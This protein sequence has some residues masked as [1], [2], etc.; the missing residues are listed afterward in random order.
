MH[1]RLMELTNLIIYCECYHLHVNIFIGTI[2]A[3][4]KKCL[5]LSS[6]FCYVN[7]HS[8]EKYSNEKFYLL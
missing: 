8:N 6:M 2:Y 4:S 1:M 7:Q 3:L 5:T